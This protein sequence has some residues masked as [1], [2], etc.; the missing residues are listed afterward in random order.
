MASTHFIVFIGAGASLSTNL[1]S[2]GKRIAKSKVIAPAMGK[3]SVGVNEQSVEKAVEALYRAMKDEQAPAETARLSIWGYGPPSPDDLAHLWEAFGRSAWIEFIPIEY[4]H[5][6]TPTRTYIENRIN[7]ILPL[8]HEVSQSLYASRKSSPLPLPL[9]NFDSKITKHLGRFWYRGLQ[10]DE[11]KKEIGRLCNLFRQCKFDG[12]KKYSDDRNLTFE[13]AADGVC[14]GQPHPTGATPRHF[15]AGRFR[16]G[17]SIFKG[18][19]YEVSSSKSDTLQCTLYDGGTVARA[20]KSEKRKY[21][22]V[23]PN[24]HLLPAP[25]QK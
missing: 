1:L 17:A 7:G 4:V 6:E 9:F 5:K 11:L 23:F 25:P 10:V 24:D 2:L 8:L 19:H 3:K 21:I 12:A 13:P 16:F 20:L 15:L 22:N 18:F 14:H